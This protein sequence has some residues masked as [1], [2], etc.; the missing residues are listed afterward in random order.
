VTGGI[1]HKPTH[2]SYRAIGGDVTPT[3]DFDCDVVVLH[4]PSYGALV[5]QIPLLQGAGVAVVVDVD[6]ALDEVR[7]DHSLRR[8]FAQ[9]GPHQGR[10]CELADLVTCST[11]ALAERYGSHGRCAVLPNC[12][13]AERLTLPR[14]SDGHTLGWAGSQRGH[15]GDLTVTGGGVAD[16]LEDS[17]WRFKLIGPAEAARVDLGLTRAPE[18]TGVLDF[19]EYQRAVGSLD[20][21]IV[22]LADSAFNRAKSGL[23]GLE[24]AVRGAAF[25]ASPLPEYET[26]SAEGVGLIAQ[27]GAEGWRKQLR[28]LMDDESFRAEE[29]AHAKQVVSDFHTYEGNAHLWLEAWGQAIQNRRRAPVTV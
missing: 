24:Y 6:D 19:D 17:D 5:E 25:V 7:S 1:V 18:V 12:V 14:D 20:I 16:A 10:A 3:L 27:G 8:V 28:R 4:R 9:W 2:R 26:L 22:P 21:G 23:K 13:P 15:V 29:A 11:P